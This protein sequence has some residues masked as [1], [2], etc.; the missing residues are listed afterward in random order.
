MVDKIF[1]EKVW[2]YKIHALNVDRKCDMIAL[3]REGW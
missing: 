2:R 1:S 3:N